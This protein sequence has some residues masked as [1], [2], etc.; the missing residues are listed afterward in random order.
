MME[1]LQ[2]DYYQSALDY[3]Q[4]EKYQEA[5]DELQFLLNA[6]AIDHDVYNFLGVIALHKKDFIG[7]EGYF[8]KVLDFYPFH[9]EVN[10]HYGYALQNLKKYKEA[11]AAYKLTID[12][13]PGNF[14]ALNNLGLV[15]LAVKNYD[16]AEKYFLLALQQSPSSPKVFNNIGNLYY[17]IEEFVKAEEYYQLASKEDPTNRDY[18]LN[19]ALSCHNGGNYKKA[20]RLYKSLLEAVADDIKI[21]NNISSLYI[22]IIEYSKAREYLFRILKIDSKNTTALF[23]LAK[24]YE[25][26][27]QYDEAINLYDK[28]SGTPEKEIS[29]RTNSAAIY[30]II[31]DRKTAESILR[32][33]FKT[34]EEIIIN[35]SAICLLAMNQGNFKKARVIFE[36]ILSVNNN[37]P[38]VHY[39]YSHLLFLEEKIEEAQLEYEWRKKRKDY[40]KRNFTKPELTDQDVEGKRVLVYDEQGIGDIIQFIRYAKYLKAKGA[41]VIFHCAY[42]VVELIKDIEGLDEVISRQAVEEPHVEYDYHIALMS[43]PYY[44]KTTFNTIPKVG[45]YLKAEKSI[46]EKWKTSLSEYNGLKVGIVW[47]GNPGHTNDK[48]RSIKLTQIKELFDI[49][50]IHY[51]AL[52]KGSGLEQAKEFSDKN[53]HILDPYIH[54]LTDTAAIIDN[55]DLVI[56]VDTAVAHIAGAMGKPV[57][58]I[59]PFA[60]DWRWMLKRNESP[61]YPSMKL[62][63]QCY[64]GDWKGVI[65]KVKLELLKLSGCNDKEILAS[66]TK[67]DV[68]HD[69]EIYLA[70]T[71]TNYFGWGICSKYLRQE[72]GK[73][74]NFKDITEEN[75]NQYKTV[76][77]T[78]LHAIN[79]LSFNSFLNVTGAKNIGYT[80]FEM[81]PNEKTIT[82]SKR[83]D[84]ILTGSTWCKNKLSEHGITNTEVLI[85]GV[86]P[87]LFFPLPRKDDDKLFVLFSGG[88]FELRKGQ[89]LVLKAFEVLHKKYPN[90]ILINSWY[91]L[92]PHLISSMSHS[93]FINFEAAGNTW[94][95]FM[96]NLL[97]INDIDKTKVISLPITPI[98]KLRE[99]YY[100]TDLGIFPNRGEGGTN[101]VLMEYM[102][103]G[104]PVVASYSTG[105]KDIV[106]EENS[107]LLNNVNPFVIEADNKKIIDWEEPDLD[108]LIYNIEFAYFNRNVIREVGKRAGE[109][110]QN[111]TWGKTADNLLK[112]LK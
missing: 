67:E 75:A 79:D 46:S 109:T 54:N 73:K 89:D 103:C 37:L 65:E 87:K 22:T 5:E 49:P 14:D 8:R 100:K 111:F 28:Y 104:K 85:Q 53:V 66:F 4:A 62:F 80:F 10:Y 21:L 50:G 48:N 16:D 95:E 105:H 77:G 29:A 41:Y 43:L 42:G 9:P 86:D 55:L 26:E 76:P 92:W 36:Y 84:L 32:T 24:T 99:L 12:K 52:Q 17:D 106:T 59:L 96:T 110:M 27:E 81:E 112:Y 57:W 3:F 88:K 45:A 72:L 31:D 61:W 39:N 2:K 51:F 98:T 20:L 97:E 15:Y 18:K 34:E 40:A 71:K 78:V 44:F 7:A 70:L 60:P 91:N 90:M 33:L 11:T 101:L 63:R 23:N 35:L 47:A 13:L 58:T 25:F 82:N 94:D 93:K 69:D 38:E 6:G 102:A 64:K 68:L 1:V 30:L 107:L 74:I 83:Y 56:S 19:L 108:E